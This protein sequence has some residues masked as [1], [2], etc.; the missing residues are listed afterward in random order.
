VIVA[1][2]RFASAEADSK[3][4][5]WATTDDG[6]RYAVEAFTDDDFTGFR[7][8]DRRF[9]SGGS[10]LAGLPVDSWR[11]TS[12]TVVS[13]EEFAQLIGGFKP[14]HYVG[15]DTLTPQQYLA[16]PRAAIKVEGDRFV[17]RPELAVG[18]FESI[19]RESLMESLGAFPFVLS[20][21][22]APFAASLGAASLGG[23]SV[24][25]EEF[26]AGM[27][28]LVPGG[29]GVSEAIAASNV[30][31][32]LNGASVGAEELFSSLNEFVPGGKGVAEAAAAMSTLT[33]PAGAGTLLETLKPISQVAG[34]ASSIATAARTVAGVT[35]SGDAAPGQVLVAPPTTSPNIFYI[36]GTETMATKA[37]AS[38]P[39]ATPTL[40][41][42]I[43]PNTIMLLAV[44]AVAVFALMEAKGK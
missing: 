5:L 17:Y 6:S 23:A 24:G 34:T 29:T 18:D 14:G 25:A 43:S 2:R 12:G 19:D 20:A 21:F 26:F 9:D 39:I 1:L 40:F 7:Q 32:S 37:A 28:S 38:T 15:V 3:G 11:W 8:V 4:Y 30:A 42:N 33:V 13:A 41:Q 36:G 44:A 22:A 31:A 27:N 16:D 35:G 10:Q